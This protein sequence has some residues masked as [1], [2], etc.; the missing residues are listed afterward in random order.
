[1]HRGR[2]CSYYSKQY[3]AE[4]GACYFKIAGHWF[5]YYIANE[6]FLAIKK[7]QTSFDYLY[8]FKIRSIL[9]KKEFSGMKFSQNYFAN[10]FF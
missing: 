3:G 2:G 5:V 1:M 8:N 4:S 9:S 6:L 10:D 7:L